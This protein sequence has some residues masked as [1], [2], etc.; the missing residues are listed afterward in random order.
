MSLSRCGLFGRPGFDGGPGRIGDSAQRSTASAPRL[1][2]GVVRGK[3]QAHH[4][5]AAIRLGDQQTPRSLNLQDEGIN[6]IGQPGQFRAAQRGC[7]LRRGVSMSRRLYQ[8][9]LGSSGPGA[10]S[11][12]VWVALRTGWQGHGGLVVAGQQAI[13]QV[14]VGALTR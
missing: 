7:G 13:G 6:R 9:L 3:R 2:G 5:L 12:T 14:A 11:G 4:A 10:Y 8:G 1:V